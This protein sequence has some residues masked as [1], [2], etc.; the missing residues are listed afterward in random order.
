MLGELPTSADVVPIKKNER[1]AK[2]LWEQLAKSD[3]AASAYLAT[4]NLDKAAE[5]GYV[6]FASGVAHD[7]SYMQF[8]AKS[9]PI[10]MPLFD[11]HGDVRSM[12][13]RAISPQE[14]GKSKMSLKG[15]PGKGLMFGAPWLIDSSPV[16][17]I[18]E[19]IADTLALQLWAPDK[20][21]AIGAAGKDAL[22]HIAETL[23]ESGLPLSGKTFLLFYQNDK[24]PNQ[25]LKAFTNLGG[26]LR[27]LGANTRFVQTPSRY[28]DVAEWRQYEPN[29]EWPGREKPKV[30]A[31]GNADLAVSAIHADIDIYGQNLKTLNA[32]LNDPS[33]REEVMGFQDLGYNEMMQCVTGAGKQLLDHDFHNIRVNLEHVVPSD[34]VCTFSK[35]DVRDAVYAL[36][37]KHS[38]HP[39]RQYLEKLRGEWDW[40]D[41]VPSLAVAMLGRSPEE[42]ELTILRLWLRKLCVRPMKPGVKADNVLILS[43]AG[44]AYKSSFC[45]MMASPVW[46]SD[47]TVDI[48]DTTRAPALMKR[49]WILEFGELESML[50]ARDQ[51]SVKQFL[52][53]PEDSF[54]APYKTETES[55]PRTSVI[56]GTTNDHVFL[57]DPTGGDRRYWPLRVADK[58]DINWIEQNRE[59]LLA[60]AVSELDDG[61]KWFIDDEATAL[62]LKRHQEPFTKAD[63]WTT[64]VERWLAEYKGDTVTT[65]QVLS[66]A[67]GADI[68]KVS[69][70]GNEARRVALI[71]QELGWANVRRLVGSR[72]VHVYARPLAKML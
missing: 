27:Q 41:R 23:E 6:K 25:S 7:D 39:V 57:T 20:V 21:A 28:K 38:Y 45:R 17:A 44:G 33:T 35:G 26:K 4:R 70:F 2:K 59:Q 66:E 65:S 16:I 10:A 15:A 37:R 56:V 69:L 53:S 40:K 12:Q 63:M 48:S 64:Q 60:Q 5:L 67:M 3:A 1:N 18:A 62:E 13:F 51:N 30:A 61:E 58:M 50:R 68:A 14:G 72:K 11:L 47:S 36:A 43:G 42:I 24:A 55:L 19:G 46:F 71:M 22:K 34:K 31:A 52:S 49:V 29:A 8:M 54:R 32:I 9:Y